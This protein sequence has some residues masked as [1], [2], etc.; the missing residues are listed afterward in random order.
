MP[1][2]MKPVVLVI[3]SWLP[4]KDFAEM[5]KCIIDAPPINRLPI[6]EQEEV[7]APRV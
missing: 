4:A 2:V 6:V 7:F 5:P 1:E 3:T